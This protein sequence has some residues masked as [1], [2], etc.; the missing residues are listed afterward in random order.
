MYRY[1]E[2]T[3]CPP[4]APV[5]GN[6]PYYPPGTYGYPPPT[7]YPYT[8]SANDDTANVEYTTQLDVQRRM[9]K[10][11]RPAM[12]RPKKQS[13]DPADILL[14]MPSPQRTKQGQ[15]R[16]KQAPASPRAS[17]AAQPR[18]RRVSVLLAEREAATRRDGAVAGEGEGAAERAID[19]EQSQER[20]QGRLVGG[21][22]RQQGRDAEALRGPELRKNPRRRT[23]YVPSEDTT[24]FTIHPGAPSH[25]HRQSLGGQA[26]RPSPDL[27]F[28]LMTVSEEGTPPKPAAAAAATSGRKSL[29]AAPKR[30]NALRPAHRNHPGLNG[31]YKDRPGS[32]PGKE[33][34][35]A[36]WETGHAKRTGSNTFQ[37][38]VGDVDNLDRRELDQE[39]VPNKAKASS[40]VNIFDEDAP[41]SWGARGGNAKHVAI[42][43]HADDS[44]KR[45]PP[46][47]LA[48]SESPAKLAK[49]S[50]RR[51]KALNGSGSSPGSPFANTGSPP[52][53]LR[54]TRRSAVAANASSSAVNRV[55]L[56][57]RAASER[58]S[59]NQPYKVLTEDL[60]CPEL[61]EENWLS[62]QEVALTQLL[63]KLFESVE[64]VPTFTCDDRTGLRKAFLAIYHEPA[65]PLLFK[66]LQASLLYG[67]LAIPKDLLAKAAR[68]KDDV[69][70]R[71]KFLA[72]WLETYDLPALRAAAEAVVGREVPPPPARLSGSGAAVNSPDVQS[73]LRRAEK[74]SIEG[75]LDCFLVKH[76]DAHRLKGG[77]GSGAGSIGSIARARDFGGAEADDFGG[78]GWAWRRTV[79][80]SLMLIQLLDKAKARGVVSG[81]LFQATSAHKSSAGV[82]GALAAMVLPSLGDVLRPLGHLN[83]AVSAVQY[84]LEELRYTV[85]N[86]ATDLRNGVLLARLV[87]IL[88]YTP[89][90]LRAL[91]DESDDA[92]L[93]I[94]MPTGEVL[95]SA[96]DKMTGGEKKSDF[97]AA[98]SWVLSQHLRY[99][100]PSR[101]Q[102]LFNVQVALSALTGLND[103]ARNVAARVR[104]EDIVDGHREKTLALLWALVAEFGLDHLVDFKE[105]KKEIRF[106]KQKLSDEGEGEE[107]FS[108]DSEYFVDCDDMANGA[109]KHQGLLLNW[110]TWVGRLHGL[111]VNN[112]TTSFASGCVYAAIA[113]EYA[114]V[115]PSASKEVTG[116]NNLTTKLRSLGCST[117]FIELIAPAAAAAAVNK[118]PS[119]SHS[120]IPTAP[121]TTMALGFL[122]ARLLPL[123]RAHR[124]ATRIQRQFRAHAL[125]AAFGRRVQLMRVAAHCAAVVRTRETVVRAAVT[126][127]TAW[128]KALE[129]R[130]EG[131]VR[132]V[133]GVQAMVRGFL[134]REKVAGRVTGAVGRRGKMRV[135]GGW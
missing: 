70:L 31:T 107:S 12:G 36:C 130:I 15:D 60:N 2:Q 41:P 111:T 58:A 27:G 113:D 128:R 57:A 109:D 132:D 47:S 64:P 93:T 120:R 19:Q 85:A 81:C 35:P 14:D 71:R 117:T 68:L 59:D 98:D 53:A 50:E 42:A 108:E 34:R 77:A 133:S 54:R 124:A 127:Q 74:K 100:A 129:R 51:V 86:L 30:A 38:D 17:V 10:P 66:R 16:A 97:D 45:A 78:Q 1:A 56:L 80:R 63:N 49:V 82:V 106:L 131:L 28:D 112:M 96:L 114:A 5:T 22:A 76:E 25:H 7:M 69:G 122:A 126:I 73:R 92:T 21:P 90:T 87:E 24:I 44:R 3:P 75:F 65:F 72:L 94:N 115:F 121:F 6:P 48:V 23:I 95:T 119:S 125:R 103:A 83:F 37:F 110:A 67:A 116:S 43:K 62:N 4:P 84:P 55:P 8:Y 101:A 104:A 32:G 134:V 99:P 11:R 20:Q 46:V 105:V 33:N 9:A 18:R 13:F 39:N 123:A 79:L 118:G 135:R 91:A 40:R 29:A 89:R 52:S 61:Y 26:R 88:L 102:K